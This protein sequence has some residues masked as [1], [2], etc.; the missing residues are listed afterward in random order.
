MYENSGFSRNVHFDITQLPADIE[1]V[2]TID[3]DEY[4]AAKR[5]GLCAPMHVYVYVYARV[6]V[7]VVGS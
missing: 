4:Y 7:Y 2:E 5:Q 3:T 1:D 6:C